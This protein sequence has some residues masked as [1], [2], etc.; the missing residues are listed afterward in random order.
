MQNQDVYWLNL[1]GPDTSPLPALLCAV[2]E[3]QAYYP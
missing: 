2:R 1:D 3:G